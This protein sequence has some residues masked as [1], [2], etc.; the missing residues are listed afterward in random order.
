MPMKKLI[1]PLLLIGSAFHK[2]HDFKPTKS[3]N[4]KPTELKTWAGKPT[5]NK[6]SCTGYNGFFIACIADGF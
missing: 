2:G 1:F 3:P 4:K 5:P 6:N